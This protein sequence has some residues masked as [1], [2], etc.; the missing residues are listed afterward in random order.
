MGRDVDVPDRDHPGKIGKGFAGTEMKVLPR[1]NA[2]GRI[3]IHLTMSVSQQ[4]EPY[5]YKI[6]DKP[7]YSIERMGAETTLTLN[8]GQTI[9]AGGLRTRSETS[10]I[11]PDAPRNDGDAEAT[12]DKPATVKKSVE[13]DQPL[14]APDG[15]RGSA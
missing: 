10:V 5:G 8:D 1:V 9:I 12:A 6:D 13:R 15:P 14:R 11:R 2:E 4:G 7:V 3:E